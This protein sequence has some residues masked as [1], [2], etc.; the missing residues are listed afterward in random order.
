L[1]KEASMRHNRWTIRI[2]LYTVL[3]LCTAWASLIGIS[4]FALYLGGISDRTWVSET[5]V[6]QLM[7]HHGTGVL[8]IT[9]DEVF[10]I[11]GSGWVPVLKRG[12]G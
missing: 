4:W 11:R 2:T 7:Q 8:K 6:Q 12:H 9:Q 5:Q 3:F 10:I 1:E